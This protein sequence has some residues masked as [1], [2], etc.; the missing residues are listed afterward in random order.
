MSDTEMRL[1]RMFAEANQL[2][3]DATYGRMVQAS[4]PEVR[5]AH[6]PV[7]RHVAP[8][9]SRIVDLAARAGMAKQ[10]MAYLVGTLKDAGY[11]DIATDP[12]DGRAN[13]I[14]FTARGLAAHA[15]LVEASLQLEKRLEDRMGRKRMALLRSLTEEVLALDADPPKDLAP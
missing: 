9:G 7:F 2:W 8:Q 14:R 4:F 13:L 12:A 5:P 6:S 3:Q 10:S 11:L 15:A 1:G